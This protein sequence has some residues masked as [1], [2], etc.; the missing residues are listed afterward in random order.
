MPPVSMSEAASE[1]L[2]EHLSEQTDFR[3]RCLKCQVELAGS[4][5]DLRSHE[6]SGGDDEEG[7]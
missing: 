5:A 2:G 4:I 1:A 6:C 7:E 3:G